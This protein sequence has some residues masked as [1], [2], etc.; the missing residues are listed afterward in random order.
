MDRNE[1]I[2][3]GIKKAHKKGVQTGYRKGLQSKRKKKS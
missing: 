1:R 3:K 2:Y